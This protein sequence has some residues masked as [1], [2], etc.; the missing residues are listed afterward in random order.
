MC[1][2]HDIGLSI[3]GG[4]LDGSSADG[5]DRAAFQRRSRC[6]PNIFIYDNYPGGIGFS[7]PAVRDARPAAGAHARTDR[8]LS[9]RFRLPVVRRSRGAHRSARQRGG[10]ADS[11]RPAGDGDRRG[12]RTSSRWISHPGSVRSFDRGPKRELTYE[13]DTGSVRSGDRSRSRCRGARRPTVTTSFG[14]CLAIDRRYESDRWHGDVQIG[15][16]ELEDC[17]ALAVARSVAAASAPARRA[18]HA[19]SSSI[20]KRRD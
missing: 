20:S 5:R 4:S 2:G 7:R 17:E 13:P 8:R 15:S 12:G 18:S 10:V 9:L 11:R 16:C 1:D 6:E 3:D 19:P 14:A